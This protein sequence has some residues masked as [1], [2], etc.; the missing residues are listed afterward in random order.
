M[1]YA[2]FKEFFKQC[3]SYNIQSVLYYKRNLLLLKILIITLKNIQ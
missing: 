2:L 3:F 1:F